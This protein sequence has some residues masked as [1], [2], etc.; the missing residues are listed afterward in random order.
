MK[1]TNQIKGFNGSKLEL[2]ERIGDLYYDSLSE[3]LALLSEKIK[4]DSE[5]DLGRG[6]RNLANHLQECASSLDI[7][8]KE[9]ESAWGIC[10]P[11][12]D[13]WL[14]NNGKTRE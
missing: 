3:L 7:A 9:I 11:Y 10:S 12:V 13:E 5:A 8:S 4:E 2:A 1:H 14:K 6:R